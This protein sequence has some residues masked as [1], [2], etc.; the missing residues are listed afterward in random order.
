MGTQRQQCNACYTLEWRNKYF[1]V[2]QQLGQES[3]ENASSLVINL[4]GYFGCWK[5]LLKW[6]TDLI[7]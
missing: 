4:P 1:K 5:K 7:Y 2:W 3:L 6:N